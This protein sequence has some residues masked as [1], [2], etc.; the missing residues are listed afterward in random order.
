M[1]RARLVL[2]AIVAG[3]MS[4][5]WSADDKK[6]DSSSSKPDNAGLLVGSWEATK[7][8]K[9]TETECMT[10]DDDSKKSITWKRKKSS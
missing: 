2:I 6:S 7:V 5:A 4:L 1:N 9:L 8:D 3:S 10:T